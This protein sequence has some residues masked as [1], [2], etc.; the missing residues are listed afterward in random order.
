MAGTSPCAGEVMFMDFT[1][2]ATHIIHPELCLLTQKCPSRV[3]A[4]GSVR[5]GSHRGSPGSALMA[6]D[7]FLPFPCF[8]FPSG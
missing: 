6:G 1:V 8:C 3:C 2:R 7:L 4:Y 5:S